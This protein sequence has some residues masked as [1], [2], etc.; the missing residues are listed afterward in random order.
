MIEKRDTDE[1]DVVGNAEK[2]K[3]ENEEIHSHAG[4]HG[5]AKNTEGKPSKQ[6]RREE[7][8]RLVIKT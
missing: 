5:T 3:A 4:A 1:A 7:W 8:K 6:K 2:E